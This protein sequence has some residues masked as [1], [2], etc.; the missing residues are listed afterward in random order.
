MRAEETREYQVGEQQ[1]WKGNLFQSSYQMRRG[2]PFRT[3]SSTN[4]SSLLKRWTDGLG[5]LLI[6]GRYGLSR[7]S[8]APRFGIGDRLRTLGRR[9]PWWKIGLA[10][11]A[12][13]IVLKKDIQFSVNMKAPA[14]SAFK[15]EEQKPVSQGIEEMNIA[16]SVAFSGNIAYAPAGVDDLDEA[17]V[18]A[19]VERF[20]RVAVSEMEKFGIPASIKI[21]QGLIESHAGDHPATRKQKNHFGI[22]LAGHS[23]ETD[24]ENWREHSLLIYHEYPSL[25]ENGKSYKSWAR[26][27][28]KGGYSKDR[29]YDQKL[30][31]VV[32]K[33]QLYLL[34][35]KI[36]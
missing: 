1:E 15:D 36:D 22:P 9:L 8:A 20:A 23:Y 28:E 31:D 17:R 35:D 18:Q 24:W 4:L 26:A 5:K 13:F 6:A 10:T 19:Y 12:V 34:D 7:L 14:V 32:E 25:L 21:A 30:I 33:F 16:Q 29:K 2:R 27:L 3:E 11:L